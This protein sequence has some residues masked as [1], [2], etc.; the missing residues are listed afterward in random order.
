V[1][2]A[3][4][5]VRPVARR[6]ARSPARTALRTPM[7]G[8]DGR[9]GSLPLCARVCR[10]HLAPPCAPCTLASPPSHRTGP[11]SHPAPLRRC[12]HCGWWGEAW[13]VP[14]RSTR[15]ACV[16]TVLA[17]KAALRPGRTMHTCQPLHSCPQFAV[18]LAS[19]PSQHVQYSTL[20]AMSSSTAQQAPRRPPLICTDLP[21]G[22]SM[23]RI[24][25]PP[26]PMPYM[27]PH[28]ESPHAP[29]HPM[30]AT[31]PALCVALLACPNPSFGPLDKLVQISRTGRLGRLL[32]Y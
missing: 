12:S 16:T 24:L 27:P 10:S 21:N 7:D 5:A 13:H 32:S 25:L 30:H 14:V 22:R 11:T 15:P 3:A 18:S 6:D 19:R 17:D 2:R 9:R 20:Y 31:S 4:R 26:I 1:T 8:P 29:I 28:A 23:I